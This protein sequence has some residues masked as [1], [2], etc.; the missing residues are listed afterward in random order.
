VRRRGAVPHSKLCLAH[1]VSSAFFAGCLGCVRS[2]VLRRRGGVVN[3]GGAGEFLDQGGANHRDHTEHAAIRIREPPAPE[4]GPAHVLQNASMNSLSGARAVQP[5]R[6][7][8]E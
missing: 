6:H 2:R 7:E 8:I 4:S 3:G 5:R 1:E